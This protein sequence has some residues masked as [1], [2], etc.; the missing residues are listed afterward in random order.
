MNEWI[1]ERTTPDHM[2]CSEEKSLFFSSLS[3]KCQRTSCIARPRSSIKCSILLFHSVF[4]MDFFFV[5]LFSCVGVDALSTA[6][7]SVARRHSTIYRNVS[8]A[9]FRSNC[10]SSCRRWWLYLLLLLRP[11]VIRT[12]F[13]FARISMNT[14]REFMFLLLLLAFSVCGM[15]WMDDAWFNINLFII[16]SIYLYL[17][18]CADE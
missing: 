13:N 1:C 3:I 12:Y 2:K 5:E 14:N 18:V 6:C 8:D 16:F 7:G 15:L 9:R 17:V 11:I 4:R 10:V